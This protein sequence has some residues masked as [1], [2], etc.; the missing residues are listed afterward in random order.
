MKTMTKAMAILMAALLALTGIGALAEGAMT[1]QGVGVVHVD[2]DRANICLGVRVVSDDVMTA[3]AAINERLDSIVKALEDK[4]VGREAVSTD[5]IGIY[6]N[7]DYSEDERITGYTAYNSIRVAVSDVGEVGAY[8]DA[9][10]EAGANSLDYV[11]F[12]AS[13]NAEAGE[14]ALALAVESAKAKAQVLAD[15]AGVEL[16]DILDITENSD[17]YYS[18]TNTFAKVEERAAGDMGTQV[19]ASSQQVTAVVNV[20][21]EISGKK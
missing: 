9:A 19:F 20:R 1:V 15:A 14:K 17:G 11:E 2:A 18:A 7:Y 10:F 13:D 8:I 6:P 12:S 4:G 3:Q 16:G 5:S 21:F